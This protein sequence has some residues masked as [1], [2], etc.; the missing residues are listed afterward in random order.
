MST[1]DKW[2]LVPCVGKGHLFD[3]IPGIEADFFPH[4]AE[5]KA[6]CAECPL[7]EKCLVKFFDCEDMIVGGKTPAERGFVPQPT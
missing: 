4:E 6:L 7:R 2:W 5:A 1:E 3:G